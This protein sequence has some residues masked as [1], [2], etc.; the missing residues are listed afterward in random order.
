MLDLIGPFKDEN[1]EVFITRR[2]SPEKKTIAA[3]DMTIADLAEI[4]E[5]KTT[6][7]NVTTKTSP[8]K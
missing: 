8:D 2:F 5:P 4:L 3:R 1:D 7:Q 6:R